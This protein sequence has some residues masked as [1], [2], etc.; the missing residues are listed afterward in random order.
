MCI[1]CVWLLLVVS[2]KKNYLI[3]KKW[4][5]KCGRRGNYCTKITFI[6][7]WME[8]TTSHGNRK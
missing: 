7:M 2:E 6:F 8:D 5:K 4:N 3:K 1:G